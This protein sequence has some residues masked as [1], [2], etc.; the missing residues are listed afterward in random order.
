MELNV[1]NLAP[2]RVRVALTVPAEE[3]EQEVRKTLDGLRRQTRMKGFR[4]GKVP[5]HAVEKAHGLEV[6]EEAKQRFVA[7]AFERAVK[8]NELDPLGSPRVTMEDLAAIRPAAGEDFEFA[9]DVDLRPR[10]ELGQYKGLAV[11]SQLAPVLEEEVDQA[12]EDIRRRSARPEPAGEDGLPEDGM[13][14]CKMELRHEGEVVLSREGMRLS[15]EAPLPG[16][17]PEAFTR[18]LTGAVPGQE[19][20]LQVPRLPVDIEKEEARGQAGTCHLTVSEAFRLVPPDEETLRANVGVE[21]DEELRAKV[22]EELERV[23]QAEEGQRVEAALI[24]AL[25]GAHDFELP[26]AMIEDQVASRLEVIRVQLKARGLADEEIG[27]AIAAQEGEVREGAQ[28]GARSL[29]LMEA[30]ATQEEL[31]VNQQDIAS[32]LRVIAQRNQA[33]LEEVSEFYKEND[34]MQQLA[35]EIMDRKV[36]TFLRENAEITEPA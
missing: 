17:D 16:L 33:S 13:A 2:C 27:Q 4:P 20:E 9:F 35:L 29:F 19:I 36:R 31:K 22:R 21:T 34:Q 8:E 1:E 14:V 30:I 25:V 10:F 26:E 11:E 7:L 6:R 15:P 28:Q 18:S 23:R 5:L 3:L 24:A 32:E 12:I